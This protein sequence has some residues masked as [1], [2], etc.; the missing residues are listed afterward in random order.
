M[1][2]LARM[3]KQVAIAENKN[4]MLSEIMNALKAFCT[5]YSVGESGV[6]TAENVAEATSTEPIDSFC[7]SLSYSLDFT[8]ASTTTF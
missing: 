5:V 7:A 8:F 6:K 2:K 3:S 4:A 1:I